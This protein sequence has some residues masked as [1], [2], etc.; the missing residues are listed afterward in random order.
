MKKLLSLVCAFAILTSITGCGGDGSQQQNQQADQ[1]A[2]EPQWTQEQFQAY[3]NRESDE[4]MAYAG[5][6]YFGN[7]EGFDANS[8]NY[9]KI[10]NDKVDEII[11][12]LD[13]GIE[14]LTKLDLKLKEQ[15]EI[16]AWYVGE[17]NKIDESSKGFTDKLLR[18]TNINNLS[19][20]LSNLLV[21]KKKADAMEKDAVWGFIQF[22]KYGD[23]VELT[24]MYTYEVRSQLNGIT[25]LYFML[26]AD[27]N[28][29]Y[30]DLNKQ[31]TAKIDPVSNE[32]SDL[33]NELYYDNAVVK[34]GE[35]ML[36]TGDYY[37]AKDTVKSLDIQIANAKKT[38]ADYTG[39]NELLSEN[40]LALYF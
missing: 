19:A 32:A 33:F 21:L 14:V 13:S 31:F 1:T 11:A 39:T 9:S 34:Y 17:I 40:M 16:Y 20:S 6:F 8:A 22:Q 18:A 24:D 23:L 5:P 28:T 7:F 2:Q 38:I 10:R 3:L 36:F 25:A 4:V 35:D 30:Q 29:A 15:K 37:F 26:E 12:V 27:A